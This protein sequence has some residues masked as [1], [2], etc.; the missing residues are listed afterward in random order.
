MHKPGSIVRARGRDW[1][2]QT[3][4]YKIDGL[5]ILE[6]LDGA[7]HTQVALDTTLEDVESSTFSL[8][9]P[10]D[11]GTAEAKN[12]IGSLEQAI[13]L[14]DAV[15]LSFRNAA[16]PFRCLSRIGVEPRPYQLVPLMMALRQEIVRLLIA[17]DVGIGKTV[18]SLLIARELHDR[19]EISGFSVLCPPHLAEQWCDALR[20]QFGYDEVTMVLS[21][22]AKRLEK[23]LSDGDDS[24]FKQHPITVVSMDFIKQPSRRD[25][26]L[27]TCPKLVIVDEAHG[28]TKREGTNKA[29]QKRHELLSELA[30]NEDQHLILVTA[31]PHSGHQD[32]FA[33]LVGLLDPDFYDIAMNE[34]PSE[35][36]RKRL[37]KHIVQRRRPDI[38][39]D[40]NDM[41]T[42][43]PDRFE[44][45][46]KFDVTA[47]QRKLIDDVI[48]WGL[49]RITEAAAIGNKRKQRVRT[50]SMLGLLRAIA[51]S[52][53][54]ALAG[55]RTRAESLENEEIVP[56]KDASLDN[57]VFDRSTEQGIIDEVTGA[58]ELLDGKSIRSCRGFH[59]KIFIHYS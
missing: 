40:F 37:A 17:D 58:D 25:S 22:T 19:G 18:E 57:R 39:R 36:Q 46:L 42:T 15:K 30:L 50:W 29:A 13:L 55:L 4:S 26:F 53:S 3:D 41:G 59:S 43:F 48:E 38:R 20:E 9:E 12:N 16:G 54:A 14:R 1:V 5:I 6:A 35:G 34:H 24:I 52:P 49:G 33:S 7:L 32:A 21:S 8:P 56:K 2:V 51:S 45:T 11:Q 28:S 27:R 10:Q 47:K 44:S 31:T 23:E